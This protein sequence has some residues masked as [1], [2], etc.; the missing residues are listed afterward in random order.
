[1]SRTRLALAATV[2]AFAGLGAGV[3]AAHASSAARAAMCSGIPC[4]ETCWLYHDIIFG[5]DCPIQ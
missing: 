1:M 2:L 4:D 5:W 3:P